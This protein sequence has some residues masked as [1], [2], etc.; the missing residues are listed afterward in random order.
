MSV[1]AGCRPL[2][3]LRFCKVSAPLASSAFKRFL[4]FAHWFQRAWNHC[5]FY[6]FWPHSKSSFKLLKELNILL[7]MI[8]KHIL[9]SSTARSRRILNRSFFSWNQET[10]IKQWKKQQLV[11]YIVLSTNLHNYVRRDIFICLLIS[12]DHLFSWYKSPSHYWSP[13]ILSSYISCRSSPSIKIAG[14]T[15]ENILIK[16]IGGKGNTKKNLFKV[17]F[18]LNV[19]WPNALKLQWL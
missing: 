3:Y 6:K 1:F 12:L 18:W 17:Y 15:Q 16:F 4:R 9:S 14:F 7:L 19:I 8:L 11:M 13:F 2:I 5:S 10:I